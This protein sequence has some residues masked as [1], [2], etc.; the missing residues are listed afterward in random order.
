MRL[1]QQPFLRQL[2]HL[3]AHRSRAQPR[4]LPTLQTR[5]RPRAHGF[6]RLD[7]ALNNGR[8]NSSLPRR[9]PLRIRH[10]SL[11]INSTPAV[12]RASR[13]P[14]IRVPHPSNPVAPS[15]KHKSGWPIQIRV[16]HPSQPYR[17]GWVIRASEPHSSP[18]LRNLQHILALRRDLLRLLRDLL[19]NLIKTLRQLRL[20]PRQ[21]HRQALISALAN[22]RI[23]LHAPQKLQPKLSRSPLRPTRAKHVDHLAIRQRHLRHILHQANHLHL[24]LMKHLQRLPRILQRDTRPSRNHNRPSQRHRLHQRD[25]HIARP[26][27][28][29]HNQKIQLPPLHLLQKLPNNLVQHRSAHHHRLIARRDQPHRN[30]LHPMRQNRLNPVLAHNIRLPR[31]P[32]HHRHIRP[33]DI[34]IDQPDPIPQL[35]QR[36]R[37]IHRN[38][39]LA[40]PTLTT[41][42]RHHMRHSRQ[43]LRPLRRAGSGPRRSCSHMS[44]RVL[45]GESAFFPN[46]FRINSLISISFTQ[47]KDLSFRPKAALS[48][49]QWRNLLLYLTQPCHSAGAT[50]PS[51][52]PTRPQRRPYL[53]LPLRLSPPHLPPPPCIF[54]PSPLMLGLRP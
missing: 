29:I 43:R 24:H 53:L 51:N 36:H 13:E 38:G 32:H 41:P 14:Q 46:R 30:E 15:L 9:D 39:R 3:I 21:R 7:I 33:I 22:L 45:L 17:E 23:K 49:P 1:L 50:H 37:Q 8:Q 12:K 18:R 40:N 20:R 52:M 26:R 28:Q 19:R 31:N 10:S 16:A 48:P 44:H 2:R 34:R 5:N 6:T 27:R 25:H 4:A 11:H 54:K 47:S 42:N 35:P